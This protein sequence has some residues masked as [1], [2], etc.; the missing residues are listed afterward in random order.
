MLA[1]F[2]EIVFFTRAFSDLSVYLVI[3]KKF[4]GKI[5][6]LQL[7]YLRI[8]DTGRRG[9]QIGGLFPADTHLFLLHNRWAKF[10]FLL[11]SRTFCAFHSTGLKA[12]SI[13]CLDSKL[14]FS[15]N[16]CPFALD[17]F[18]SYRCITYARSTKLL[19]FFGLSGLIAL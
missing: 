3:S 7:T 5:S 12:N 15:F 13:V 19:W 1:V 10:F 6:R 8:L 9:T 14:E 11:S 2:C 17:F 16:N 18:V 4:M